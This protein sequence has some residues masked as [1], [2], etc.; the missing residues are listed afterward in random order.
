MDLLSPP[1]VHLVHQHDKEI[2]ARSLIAVMG[3]VDPYLQQIMMRCRRLLAA[4]ETEWPG[5]SFGPA[6]WCSK[7]L[8]VP[9]IDILKQGPAVDIHQLHAPTNAKNGFAQCFG[10]A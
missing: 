1:R 6:C 5:S 9:A 3:A 4:I 10:P 7:A 8:C 2:F